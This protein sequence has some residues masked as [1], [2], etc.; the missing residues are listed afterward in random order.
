M[1]WND[2]EL[3]DMKQ[4]KFKDLK[5]GAEFECYGDTLINY[6]YPKICRCIK[7]SFDCT[8]EIDG[9]SFYVEQSA[10]VTINI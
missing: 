2:V 7:T 10:I 6:N 1:G 3:N 9:I 8:E 4:I 5:I